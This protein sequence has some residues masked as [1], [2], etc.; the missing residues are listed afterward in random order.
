MRYLVTGGAGFIG[1]NVVRELLAQG[2]EVVV[3][4]DFST[5]RASN[6][7]GLSGEVEVVRGS[8]TDA[9]A[10]R[11]AIR[12]CAGAFHLAAVASVQRS[13]DEPGWCHEVN[14]TGA[15]NVLQCAKE[16]GVSRVVLSSSAATYGEADAFP[17]DEG[18]AG[19][20]ISPYGMHKL[21]N[22]YY[23]WLYAHNGWVETVCLRYFNVYGPRQDPQGEYAAVVP[24][25]ITAVLGGI[26]P[27]VFG[28]GMQSR[29]FLYVGDVA[30]ANWAAMNAQGC[31]GQVFNVC[32]GLENSLLDLLTAIGRATGKP[33]EP[34][35]MPA[36]AGDIRRSVGNPA[37]AERVLGFKARVSFEEGLANT[38]E[39]FGAN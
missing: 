37:A 15:L 30:R 5:G 16:M 20:P 3:L 13:I 38:V 14:V 35:F 36:R 18:V 17:L 7:A 22:E 31:S 23:A 19:K 2:H 32:A 8:I 6:L 9:G 28:D 24:K 4:D 21:F 26:K 25:F 11:A 29:D 33:V 12:G 10:V 1:S 27:K 34:H 39:Y